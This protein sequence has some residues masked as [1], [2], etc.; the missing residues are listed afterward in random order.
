MRKKDD[1]KIY[2]MKIL[3]KE[4]IL[5]RKQYEHTLSER[6]VLENID[7]PFIVSLRFAFQSEHKLYMVF[8]EPHTLVAHFPMAPYV[9][10]YAPFPPAQTSS[11]AGSCTTTC[12]R[13]GVSLRTVLGSTPL[14]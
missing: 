8:G 3:K 4:M 2:A 10:S 14:S 5:K 9:H 1:G 6:R 11:T 13:E 12:R 7:H